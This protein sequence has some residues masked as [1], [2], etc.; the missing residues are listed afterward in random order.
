MIDAMLYRKFLSVS[1]CLTTY[2]A[3]TFAWN[4]LLG[5]SSNINSQR[6]K[7]LSTKFISMQIF[8]QKR[9]TDNSGVD[10]S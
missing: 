5:C 8:D 2:L 4:S 6:N 7:T 1:Y 9:T 3:S 10:D